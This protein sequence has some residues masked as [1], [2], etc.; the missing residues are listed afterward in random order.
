MDMTPTQMESMGALYGYGRARARFGA[1]WK[2]RATDRLYA[3]AVHLFPWNEWVAASLKS[4]YGVSAN[5]ITAISPGVDQELFRPSADMRAE[6][7]RVRLLFVGGDFARKGG[8]LLLRWAKETR[9]GGPWELHLVTRDIVPKR[10]A[11]WCITE[12]PTIARHWCS[13]ISSVTSLCCRPAPTATR[14][15]QW[16]R[17]RAACR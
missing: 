10:Q 11:W 12:L 15:W 16:K 5:K 3:Q 13:C 4:D 6:D 8:D 17:C 14:W 7:G 9:I 2:R 1:G